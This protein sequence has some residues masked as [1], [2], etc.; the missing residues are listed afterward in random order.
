MFM[1]GNTYRAQGDMGEERNPSSINKT[2][3]DYFDREPF[4]L[5]GTRYGT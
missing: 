1:L 3:H 5:L 2:A 4:C